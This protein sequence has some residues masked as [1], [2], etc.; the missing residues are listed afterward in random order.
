MSS[1][2]NRLIELYRTVTLNGFQATASWVKM[3]ATVYE[4][5]I[6]PN[7]YTQNFSK[8]MRDDISRYYKPSLAENIRKNT[9][10][11]IAVEFCG[12]DHAA[13]TV[14]RDPRP[15]VMPLEAY[16]ALFLAHPLH[17]LVEAY[18]R[19][20]GDSN[21]LLAWMT[22]NRDEIIAPVTGGWKKETAPPTR[23][24][25]IPSSRFLREACGYYLRHLK[26]GQGVTRHPSWH[27]IL[28]DHEKDVTQ[29]TESYARFCAGLHVLGK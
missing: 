14:M 13:A 28:D 21:E 9:K 20:R 16:G 5:F 18:Y 17:H 10:A 23:R 7:Y 29:A 22:E 11:V 8:N 26:T 24:D 4:D 27:K 12:I 15:R 19:H 6:P 25:D 1:R 3:M 2:E